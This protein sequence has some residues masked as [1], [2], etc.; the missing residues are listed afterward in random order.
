[1]DSFIWIFTA[2]LAVLCLVLFCL[3]FV[4]CFQEWTAERLA[5]SVALILTPEVHSMV[6][7]RIVRRMRGSILG[8]LAGMLVGLAILNNDPPLA[9]L[10]L[11][12]LLWTGVALA[13][14]TVGA[15]ITAVISGTR[16]RDDEIRIARAE[17]TSL[18]DYVAPVERFGARIAVALVTAVLLVS[19]TLGGTGLVNFATPLSLTGGGILG[20]LAIAALALFELCGRWI[21]RRGQPV[22]SPAQ[23]SWD[24][25]LRSALLRDL[26]MAPI[27]LGGY[28]LILGLTELASALAAAGAHPT[29]MLVAANACFALAT[30]TIVLI[31]IYVVVSKPQ[32]YFRLRL[33]PELAEGL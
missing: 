5:R 1:M 26:A 11:S 16:I 20:A 4:P 7:T 8:C 23:L 27:A 12:P 9:Q 32:R 22:D 17:A 15:A 28:G 3:S 13:G 30:I 24:D 19:L 6:C 2:V 31:A 14:T 18:D 21:V 33:W 25:A 29:G 10:P